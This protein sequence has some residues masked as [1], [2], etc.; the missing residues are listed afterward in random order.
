M[1]V[2]VPQFS[3]VAAPSCTVNK[4]IVTAQPPAA[5]AK[6]M[7]SNAGVVLLPFRCIPVP[8]KSM[9]SYHLRNMNSRLQLLRRRLESPLR[10]G[11]IST[12]PAHRALWRFE[13]EPIVQL[14]KVLNW[15][16]PMREVQEKIPLFCIVLGSILE[17]T[18]G[19]IR[20]REITERMSGCIQDH[21]RKSER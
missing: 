12:G 8:T 17:D 5:H 19:T 14:L 16:V 15:S 18:S 13:N 1:T 7:A 2:T 6:Q 4:A 11:S 3:V 21:N 10:G 20:F 9:Q